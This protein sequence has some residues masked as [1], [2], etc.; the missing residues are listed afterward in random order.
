M[1]ASRNYAPCAGRKLHSA[2]GLDPY[3][4]T[5]TLALSILIGSGLFRFVS[6]GVVG[7]FLLSRGTTSALLLATDPGHYCTTIDVLQH[8]LMFNDIQLRRILSTLVSFRVY[9]V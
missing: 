4:S 6:L 7:G 8:R 2:I 9:R 5:Q 3:E 1:G